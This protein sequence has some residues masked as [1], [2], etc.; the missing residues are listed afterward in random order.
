M[1]AWL[2]ITA[3]ASVSDFIR[4]DSLPPPVLIVVAVSML[5]P[6]L[7]AFCGVGRRLVRRVSIRWLIG[8][9]A[10]RLPLELVLHSWYEQ[11]T[12]PVQMTYEGHNFDIVSGIAAL[13]VLLIWRKGQ[14]PRSVVLGFNVL[15][16]VLLVTVAAI[17][18]MSTPTPLRVY[19]DDPAVLLAFHFPYSW[20]VPFCVGAALFGHLT[21]FLWLHHTAQGDESTGKPPAAS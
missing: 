17:A 14:V 8:F 19:V 16:S 1:V 20:I 4:G 2:G 3:L 10:F 5:V 7:A 11:G 6:A 9:Q 21:V 13:L 15:G 12:L 18:M